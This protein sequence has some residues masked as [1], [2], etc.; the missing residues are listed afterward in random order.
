MSIL[1]TAHRP[2]DFYTSRIDINGWIVQK[3]V[4][5][6]LKAR[7]I[8]WGRRKKYAPRNAYDFIIWCSCIFIGRRCDSFLPSRFTRRVSPRNQ[9]MYRHCNSATLQLVALTFTFFYSLFF[10]LRFFFFTIYFSLIFF[11]ICFAS[12]HPISPAALE[13]AIFLKNIRFRL[14]SFHFYIFLSSCSILPGFSFVEYNCA[15]A[16]HDVRYI[17]R[18]H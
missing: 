14:T 10:F 12:N 1:Q 7:T 15:R 3:V 13:R 8:D 9:R 11:Y 17:S 2:Y 16:D 4:T 5:L 18:K 6:F